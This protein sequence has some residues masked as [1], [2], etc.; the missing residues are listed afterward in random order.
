MKYVHINRKFKFK[1]NRP[2][3]EQEIE[4]HLDPKVPLKVEPHYCASLIKA[5][6]TY[7]EITDPLTLKK[8]MSAALCGTLIMV[9]PQPW[10]QLKCSG[11]GFKVG[12]QGRRA[13]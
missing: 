5:N 4:A 7:L 9:F 6:S 2:L 8:G 13:A 3:W 11:L 10:D 12:N 1:V